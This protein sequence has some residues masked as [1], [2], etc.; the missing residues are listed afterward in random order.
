MICR[1]RWIIELSCHAVRRAV[2]RGIT[3][4]MIEST[5]KNGRVERFGKNMLKFVSNYKRGNVIC[6]GEMKSGNSIKILTI[7]WGCT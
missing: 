2:W 5:I 4:D 7:E 3:P 6:V 1:D